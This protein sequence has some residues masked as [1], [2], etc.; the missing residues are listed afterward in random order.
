MVIFDITEGVS[1]RYSADI[2]D[3]DDLP[4]D[5]RLLD[6]LV[7]TLVD[8]H[9]GTVINGRN[10]Q[11]MLVNTDVTVSNTGNL[12]WMLSANDTTMVGST[13][14]EDH[15]ASFEWTWSNGREGYH[16]FGVRVHKR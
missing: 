6:T 14:V 1:G 8:K 3:C 12:V 11:N 13:Q 7:L 2:V 15:L 4:L 16:K 9:T 10:R 5:G